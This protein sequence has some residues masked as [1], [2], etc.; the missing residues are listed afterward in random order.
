MADRTEIPGEGPFRCAEEGHSPNANTGYIDESA[1][2]HHIDA[3]EGHNGYACP[4]SH[5]IAEIRYW[6]RQRVYAMEQR[7]R[8]DLSLAAFLR[9]ALGWSKAM[10][11]DERR[12][13]NAQALAL[14]S[15]GEKEV[16]GRGADIDEPAYLEW[17]NVILA[18]LAARAP[19]DTIEK[20]AEK[21]MRALAESLPVWRSFGEAVKGFGPVSL[22]IIIAEAGDLSS[23]PKKGHL[24]KRMGVAVLDGVRQGGLRKSASADDWIAHGYNRQR[25]SRMWN[26]G[27]ALVKGNG[28]GQYRQVYIERKEY[29]RKRAEKIGLTVAPAAKI[30]A[31]R[32]DEFMSE[33]HVHRR[34]QRYMEKR[35]LRDLWQAWRGQ[36]Q[37]AERSLVICPSELQDAA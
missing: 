32:K 8:A 16:K 5:S 7:K 35:L 28:N 37:S 20:R 31:K 9:T 11:D 15:M 22:A 30:P 13:I 17:R 3:K 18:S 25:R 21:E 36:C 4:L 34:A 6:H 1:A 27:D 19:F 29:E 10:P 33:G 14:I 24:W 26:I 12:R 23:Y 2:G